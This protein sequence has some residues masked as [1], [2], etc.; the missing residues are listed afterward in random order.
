MTLRRLDLFPRL[1]TSFKNT[2][3]IENVNRQLGVYT[4]RVN[5]WRNSD[6]QRRWVAPALL[7][8]K[9]SMRKVTIGI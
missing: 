8:I 4:G 6:Q 7:E 5:Y 3:S 2:N 1:G 9:P